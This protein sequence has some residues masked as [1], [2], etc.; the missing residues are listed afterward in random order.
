MRPDH[1]AKRHDDDAKRHDDDAGRREGGGGGP[2][3]APPG[4]LTEAA[5]QVLRGALGPVKDALA[6]LGDVPVVGPGVKQALGALAQVG[7]DD[8]SSFAEARRDFA[9]EA[10]A[11][12]EFA[13]RRA[14][15]LAPNAWSAASG[16]ENAEFAH[17]DADG[18][19]I[20]GRAPAKPGDFVRITLPFTGA[21]R[22]D[23]VRVEHVIEE[24]DRVAV[25]VRPSHDPTKRPLTPE[26]IAHFF[27]P[28][29]T[30]TFTL[31]REG[32]TL[33]AQI[34]GLHECANTGPE[35]GSEAAAL[36]HRITAE[37]GWGARR[38]DLP[39][40][41]AVDGPQQHQWNRF[42][43]NLLGLGFVP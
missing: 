38:P 23:W 28:G 22:C 26:V 4:G 24:A 34:Y 18:Q 9:D 5:G 15:L 21:E 41:T 2:A 10:E 37:A 42:T 14:E 8:V 35:A 17:H 13:K 7:R 25:V 30:N 12:A 3:A 36:R 43:A 29:A 32:P 19:G 20:P 27:G 40:D 39:P 11:R 31:V 1:D 33:V 16:I 6:K